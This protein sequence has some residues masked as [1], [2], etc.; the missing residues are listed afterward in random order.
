MLAAIDRGW[1]PPLPRV[2]TVRSMLHVNNFALAVRA[3]LE[4]RTFLKPA[5]VVTDAKPYSTREV[6]DLLRKGLGRQPPRW[7]VPLWALSLGARCGDILEGILKKPLPLSSSTLEKLIGQACHSPDA[8]I[9]DMGYRPLY[10][11]E[12]AVPE[13]IEHYRRSLS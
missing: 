3:A 4:A 8:V 6:Y 12:A 7:R 1:F 11:F 2:T 9:R 13:L 10:A 5:Y